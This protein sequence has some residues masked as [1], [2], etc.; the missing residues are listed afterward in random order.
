MIRLAQTAALPA[1]MVGR[2]P[3]SGL[4]DRL[5]RAFAKTGAAMEG[6]ARLSAI[7]DETLRDI[8]LSA[9]TLTGEASHDPALPFFLQSGFGRN[10]R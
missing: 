5:R 3:R 10:D 1:A 8:R 7:N 9:E 6:Q 2:S 4:I